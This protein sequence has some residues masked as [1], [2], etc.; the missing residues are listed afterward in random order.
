[1]YDKLKK[2]ACGEVKDKDL[3][4]ILLSTQ[5]IRQIDEEKSG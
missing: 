2:R 3:T 1:M 4:P 5:D